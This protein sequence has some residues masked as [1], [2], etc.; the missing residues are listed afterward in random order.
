MSNNKQ[1]AIQ[2]QITYI[3]NKQLWISIQSEQS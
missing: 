3:N 2:K 1:V